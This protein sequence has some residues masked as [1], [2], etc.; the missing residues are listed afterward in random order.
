MNSSNACVAKWGSSL[1]VRIPKATLEAAQ[2]KAGDA[3][4]IEL[5]DRAIVIGLPQ[6]DRLFRNC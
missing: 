4:K 2:W 1:A 5:R 6:I 3:L